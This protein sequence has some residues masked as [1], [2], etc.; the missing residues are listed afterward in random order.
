MQIVDSEWNQNFW[1]FQENVPLAL[2]FQT[3]ILWCR[4]SRI[5][6]IRPTALPHIT[7]CHLRHTRWVSTFLSRLP[8]ER[9]NERP[10]LKDLNENHYWEHL[11]PK[12]NKHLLQENFNGFLK[13]LSLQVDCWSC[14]SF[15]VGCE[16]FFPNFV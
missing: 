15:E 14:W 2:H 13:C 4:P 11:V 8:N 12:S 3:G 7:L 9:P 16:I 10:T 5:T 1:L 6:T